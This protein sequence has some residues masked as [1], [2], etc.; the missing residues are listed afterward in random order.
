M[1]REDS[2]GRLDI[3]TQPLPAS[4]IATLIDGVDHRQRNPQATTVAG[5]ALDSMGGAI[6]RVAADATA[7]VHR[8]ALCIAQYNATWPTGAPA[9][10]VRSNVEGLDSLYAAMRPHASGFAYQNYIDATLPD[11]Q[12]AYFGTNLQRL[13]SVKAR[14]DPSN[15]FHFAQSIPVA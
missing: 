15:F 12:N 7:F 8:S 9:A 2:M 5:V 3:V 4:A 14:R 10:V 1:E 11:W 6:N 13:I